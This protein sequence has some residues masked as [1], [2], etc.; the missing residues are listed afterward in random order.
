MRTSVQLPALLLQLYNCC[1]YEDDAVKH[2]LPPFID[3]I[4]RSSA[5]PTNPTTSSQR[6]SDSIDR[7]WRYLSEAV[8]EGMDV[9][10]NAG[11]NSGGKTGR[12]RQ[13]A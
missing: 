13:P 7:V 1:V 4:Y 8:K 5:S 11:S 2:T 9:Q 6:T 12:S 3:N 10:Y